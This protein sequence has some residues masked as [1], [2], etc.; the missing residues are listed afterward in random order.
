MVGVNIGDIFTPTPWS[1]RD[2]DDALSEAK[3]SGYF[4]CDGLKFWHCDP[5]KIIPVA[6]K[7]YVRKVIVHA[8][9]EEM[10]TVENWV[11]WLNTNLAPI[12][13]ALRKCRVFKDIY[14]AV[15]N[16]ALAPWHVARYGKALVK[17]LR[18]VDRALEEVGLVDRVK[19]ITPFQMSILGCSFPPSS[20]VISAEHHH[21]V[22]QVV[23]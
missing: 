4:S 6:S 14:L 18:E 23:R 10:L 12:V 15:G 17:C 7:D 16:E 22:T 9:N 1:H 2:I 19:V 3:A 8:N 11:E 20:S 5:E 13:T 21:V